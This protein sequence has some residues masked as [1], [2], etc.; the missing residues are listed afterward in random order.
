MPLGTQ[1]AADRSHLHREQPTDTHI[2]S[3]GHS[4]PPRMSASFIQRRSNFRALMDLR[5]LSQLATE[6]CF[7]MKMFVAPSS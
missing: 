3:F 1:A 7:Q 5:S 6:P 4:S 2:G